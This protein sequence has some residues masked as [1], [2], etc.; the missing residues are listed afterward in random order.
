MPRV[1]ADPDAEAAL[2][3]Y[4]DDLC[5]AVDAAIRPWVVGLVVARAPELE[6]DATAVASRVADAAMPR[7]RELLAADLDAQRSTPLQV[8]RGS[9]APVTE[10]LAAAGV[11]APRRD[12]QAERIDPGDRY[13]LGPAA[14][15]DLGEAVAEAG[16]TWGAAKAH[17][18]LARRR[19]AG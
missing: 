2:R 8:L 13:D 7:L 19:A 17:V 16:L 18:H 3:A 15:A 4:A 10:L 12:A 6:D 11:P 9:L 5:V 1:P 14:F